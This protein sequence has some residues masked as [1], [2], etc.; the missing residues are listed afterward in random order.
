MKTNRYQKLFVALLILAQAVACFGQAD[1]A[2]EPAVLAVQ[3][4]RG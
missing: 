2:S 3:S 1:P 4:A